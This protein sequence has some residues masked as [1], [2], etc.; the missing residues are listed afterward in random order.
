M[1]FSRF[2]LSPSKEGLTLEPPAIPAHRPKE[3]EGFQWGFW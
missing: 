3:Q 1:V 2:I